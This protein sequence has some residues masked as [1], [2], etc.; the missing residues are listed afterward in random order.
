M[1]QRSGI[2]YVP[3]NSTEYG[4]AS[5]RLA[6]IQTNL[7]SAINR[8]VTSSL[9][10]SVQRHRVEQRCINA[11]VY[12]N[13]QRISSFTCVYGNACNVVNINRRL[14]RIF[15]HAQLKLHFNLLMRN[16]RCLFDEGK[17]DIDRTEDQQSSSLYHL[18]QRDG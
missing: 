6:H 1:T 17:F 2:V 12:I 3:Y 9:A 13:K 10:F 5:S 14:K 16:I 15:S 11:E 18:R 8:I 4:F 7:V